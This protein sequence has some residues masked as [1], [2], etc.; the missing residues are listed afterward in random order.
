MSMLAPMTGMRDLSLRSRGFTGA[1]DLLGSMTEMR[2]LEVWMSGGVTGDIG[3]LRTMTK[4]E[5]LHLFRTSVGGDVASLGPMMFL[6][7]VALQS[8]QVS[9][10]LASFSTMPALTALRID[11]TSIGGSIASLCG[12]PDPLV[13][14]HYLIT[15]TLA[16]ARCL[17]R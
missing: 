3:G 5:K 9:G 14:L 1:I 8:T 4:L 17:R 6:N 16:P 2:T 15:S 10:D 11:G 7:D 12:G 13:N